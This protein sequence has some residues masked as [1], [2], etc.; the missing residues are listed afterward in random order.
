[1]ATFPTREECVLPEL[2]RAHAE[3]R[4]DK[5]FA[6]FEDGDEWTYRETAGRTW[7]C[8]NGLRRLGLD[9]REPLVAWLP[10]GKEA[11]LAWFGAAAAGLVYTPLNTAYKGALLE[12]ALN[13]LQT[14]VLVL[15]AGLVDR[16][17]G[18]DLPHL[19][20]LVIVGD[21][22]SLPDGLPPAVAWEEVASG[23]DASPP[24][25]PTP[26][27]PWDDQM[28]MFTGGT[29]GASKAVRRTNV[30]YLKMCEPSFDQVGIG[31]DD[32]FFVCAPMFHG[33]ADVP[34][35]S[36]L[37][38]G[39]SV[40]I[41]TGFSTSRFWADIRRY[42]CTVAW[43]HSAMAHFLWAQPESPGDRDHPL[44]LAMQAPL[45]PTMKEFAAR[46]GIRL[47]TVYGMTEIPCPFSILDPVDHR[48][49]GKP[50]DPD[51]ELRLVDEHDRE[52]PDG[53]PGELLVR[54]RIAWAITPGYLHNPEATANVWRNGWF[55]SGDVFVRDADGN[56]SLVGRVKDSIRR[57]G[58]NISAAEVERELLA[59]E[60]IA[61]AAVIGIRADVEQDV[62]AF[63]VLRPAAEVA[64]EE[65][66]EF[67][68]DRLPYYAVPRYL[69]FVDELPRTIALRPD[70]Q[71]LG[72]RG[73]SDATW[74]REA[75]GIRLRRE[76][77]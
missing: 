32:R 63:L 17:V 20:Q 37:R 69:E 8:G 59:H 7:R 35:Y 41:V 73:V 51:V 57:R 22:G 34:I 11:L 55:H 1:V 45:L 56:Y 9:Q 62:M 75:A 39:G 27:E 77:L 43:I 33:G 70:K 67:V 16:L 30:L 65:L 19:E 31:A 52:V 3:R 72:E 76:R 6:V 36:M 66:I 4:P 53:T 26:I 74:D 71:V 68:T 54:H 61:D 23:E 64:P 28:I 46:F 15:H 48:T 13:L 12:N 49:L 47:Y 58:E 42:E 25:L 29:T 60:A 5:A 38:H 40:A 18:L 24:V 10:N 14:R 44:R 21:A 50:W 2:L